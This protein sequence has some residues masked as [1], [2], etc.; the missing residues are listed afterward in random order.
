[1]RVA[2]FSSKSY[3]REFL[4]RANAAGRHELVFLDARLDA[5][6]VPAAL[7]AQAVCAFVNDRLDREVLQRLQ[8][9]GVRLVALR[10]AGFNHVDLEQAQALGIAVA[11]VPEYSPY[12]V[13]EHTAALVL[14]LDR[15]IHRAHARVREGNFAL[16]GLLG[17]DLH[18][19]TVGVVGTGKIGECFL[20]IMGGF[21]CRLLATDPQPSESC[22]QLG[23]RYVE[24]PQLL[25]DA[26]VVSLHC[27][28]TPQT[29]HLIDAPAL[30]RMKRGAMLVNTSRG[31]V[32]DTRAVIGALK[33]G[34]L[35]SLGIDVYEEE[36]DLFF[37]DLSGEVIR[38]DVFARL[39]TFPN[40]LVT[41]HQ[42]FFTEEALTAIAQVTLRNLDAF[43]DR[44]QP[45]YPVTPAR[46]A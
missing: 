18:G 41:A 37:R 33:S 7:G 43:E 34:H 31:A 13:A 20:R 2:V 22:R 11:R 17:F 29:R 14:S 27:P 3:D 1:M 26:D 21:G 30:A 6:T 32:L 36:A 35:G 44:G 9:M 42:A 10:S 4:A 39:L 38:D 46:L 12:A 45:E 28:L 15:K 8:E 24:L 5:A 16:E 40:V 25:A 23:V 19:R